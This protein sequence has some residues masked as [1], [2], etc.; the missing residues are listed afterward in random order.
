MDITSSTKVVN[1]TSIACGG[2]FNVTHGPSESGLL[3]IILTA[4]LSVAPIC[5]NTNDAAR[6]GGV[7]CVAMAITA[8]TLQKLK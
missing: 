7:I 2:T 1:V 6:Q 4:P 8:A 3:P 5:P